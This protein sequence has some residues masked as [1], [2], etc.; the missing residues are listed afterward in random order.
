MTKS[1]LEDIGGL[2]TCSATFSPLDGSTYPGMVDPSG[3]ISDEVFPA[4]EQPLPTVVSPT[5]D[6]PGY[7]TDSN[8]EY[9]EEDPA[10][11]P[12]DKIDNDDDDDD[13]DDDDDVEMSIREQP[14]TPFWSEA[15]IAKLL[16]MP[17]P[18]PSP[19]YLWSSPLPLSLRYEVGE[20]S[21]APTARPTGGF[22]AD[23]GFVA[24]L[25]DEIRCDPERDTKIRK[26]R[27]VDRRRQAQLVETLTLM[28]TLQTQV[29]ILGVFIATRTGLYAIPFLAYLSFSSFRTS[30]KAL[31]PLVEI[32]SIG[33]LRS[34]SLIIGPVLVGGV[35]CWL[36]TGVGCEAGRVAGIVGGDCTSGDDV[37]GAGSVDDDG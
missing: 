30:C 4:E 14:P 35:M 29:A 9:P 32:C 11:Y 34:S 22:R 37:D 1:N 12:S 21:C 8:P 16:D 24:T 19:L 36:G 28:R 18:P 17:S 7:I 5:I 27:A 33:F 26:L 6:L 31:L 13:E 10:D 23:Y 2:K 15:E 25:D 20:S 3:A